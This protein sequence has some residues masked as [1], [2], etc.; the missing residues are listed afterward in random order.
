MRRLIGIAAL[1]LALVASPASA[2]T[3]NGGVWAMKKGDFY[4]TN[5]AGTD[6]G[7]KAAS[8]Y[9]G[10]GGEIKVG[11]GRY[12]IN[13]TV[14]FDKSGQ[15]ISGAG[16]S[17]VFVNNAVGG[18]TLFAVFG[19]NVQLRNF[20]IDG[21][22]PAATVG[23]GIFI[24][25]GTGS[26]VRDVHIIRTP[27]AAIHVHMGTSRVHILDNNIENIGYSGSTNKHGII[28]H[29]TTDDEA[30]GNTISGCLDFGIWV[31]PSAKRVNIVGNTI[32]GCSDGVQADSGS[33]HIN[34]WS[35]VIRGN[36]HDGVQMDA[37][38]SSVGGNLISGNNDFGLWS[39]I[40][41]SGGSWIGNTFANNGNY[42]MSVT[43]ET[44]H[45]AAGWSILSNFMM[46]N[47]L[48]L[49][50]QTG[51]GASLSNVMVA[52]NYIIGSSLNKALIR[53]TPLASSTMD[54][55]EIVGNVMKNG[56]NYGIGIEPSGAGVN[57][58]RLVIDGN[59]IYDCAGRGIATK[60]VGTGTARIT[61][62]ILSGNGSVSGGG[63]A[64]SLSTSGWT[65]EGFGIRTTR[66]NVGI[67]SDSLRA[68]KGVRVGPYTQATLPSLG[69]GSIVYCVDCTKST[70]CASGGSGAFAHRINGSW[71]CFAPSAGGTGDSTN[72][73]YLPGRTNGQVLFGSNQTTT[74]ASTY[75]GLK[76]YNGAGAALLKLNTTAD[77]TGNTTVTGKATVTDS[78]RVNSRAVVDG[79]L[80]VQS[81]SW[82]A[83]ALNQGAGGAFTKEGSVGNVSMPTAGNAINFSA[84]SAN[85]VRATDAA[86]TLA[87][88]AG[89]GSNEMT[90]TAGATQVE[91][92]LTVIDSVRVNKKL[93]ADAGAFVSGDSWV[94]GNA[95][96]G[97]KVTVRD[98]IRVDGQLNVG[99]RSGVPS[100]HT[101]GTGGTT[102]ADSVTLV[103]NG[104]GS[105]GTEYAPKLALQRN[106]ATEATLATNGTN[107]AL[108]WEQGSNFFRFGQLGS[109]SFIDT[110][111][112]NGHLE[113]GTGT[114]GYGLEVN[115]DAYVLDSLRVAKRINVDQGIRVTGDSWLSGLF[116]VG[117]SL[118]VNKKL[119][120]DAGAF[121]TGSSWVAGDLDVGGKAT[122]RD[123]VRANLGIQVGGP[124]IKR[125][126]SATASL[127][128]DLST[129][130][131]ADLTISVP[132]AAVGDV[133]ILGAPNEPFDN[134][135]AG[136]VNNKAFAWVSSAGTVSVRLC[137]DGSGHNPDAGTFRATVLQF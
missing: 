130:T 90:L 45:T 29:Q 95:D 134:S 19:D 132:G 11:P 86:G 101:L 113:I 84:A 42:A 133:V 70:P 99:R 100:R 57:V 97:G 23:Q 14:I 44:G 103:L 6:A 92:K 56:V 21:M 68:L 98:S 112:S 128:F 60:S 93:N 129:A 40:A 107:T 65:Y 34:V 33:V 1:A 31:Q 106:G 37:D 85:T 8:D 47:A 20:K 81:A 104:G 4:A 131:C 39:E 121:V 66:S 36:L 64:E 32:V 96:V 102:T 80:N 122:V 116:T 25:Q 114:P 54:K 58:T 110:W 41:G 88:S 111:D 24:V 12:L 9:A 48:P 30:I 77:I 35:N 27:S 82:I 125:I 78:L 136:E 72:L 124:Q 108:R 49:E 46:N 10:A 71:D 75:L 127:D 117:D 3:G 73:A 137:R 94:A 79:G 15:I 59:Q 13:S 89:G 22:A 135:V 76:G 51:I 67:F 7:I 16:D 74:G 55:V 119:T 43:V 109:T 5:F 62:N 38:S 26:T 69:D 120:A 126:L 118:R 17:T 87:F 2:Y 123:S 53:L 115:A 52:N 83:G 61:D 63:D 18:D 105:G 28:F 91:Q 50:L